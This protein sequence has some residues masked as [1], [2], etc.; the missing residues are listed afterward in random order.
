MWRFGIAER[1][2]SHRLRASRFSY[3]KFILF[4][5]NLRYSKSLVWVFAFAGVRLGIM[6]SLALSDYLTRGWR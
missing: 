6:L 5:R 3:R 4:F 2:T 1:K